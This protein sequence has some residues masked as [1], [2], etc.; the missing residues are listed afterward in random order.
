MKNNKYNIAFIILNYKTAEDSIHLLKSIE[1][2]I[3]HHDIKIYIVDNGSFDD[4]IEKLKNLETRL[5]FEIIVSDINSGYAR[6]NN[7]GIQKALADGYKYIVISNSDILIERQD[8]FLERIYKTYDKNP[9]IAVIAPSIVNLDNMQQN[10]FRRERFNLQE[11]VKM[12]IFYL[13]GFYKLYYFLRVYIFYGFITY[14]AQFKKQKRIK[15]T[16]NQVLDS[17]YIYAPHGSFLIFT[18]TYFQYFDGFDNNTFLYCEEFILA[19]RL[20]Q[21]GLKCWY[22]NRLNVLHKESQSREKVVKNYKEKVKFTL[23]HTFDSCRYFA[24]IIKLGNL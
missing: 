15:N 19:E 2:Q 10:P 24:K 12:K 16:A 4:S 11:I 6:G 1:A 9:S 8:D 22:E 21:K 3:W 18:P 17:G 13:S 14:M 7:L 23:K 20:R 5:N